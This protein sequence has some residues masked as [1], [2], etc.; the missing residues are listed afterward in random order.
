MIDART[1]VSAQLRCFV[2]VALP[3]Q[4]PFVA[5]LL[6]LLPLAIYVARFQRLRSHALVL[7]RSTSGSGNRSE[8]SPSRSVARR[9]TSPR[10]TRRCCCANREGVNLETRKPGRGSGTQEGTSVGIAFEGPNPEREMIL[11]FYFLDFWLP[12]S[13]LDASRMPRSMSL[14]RRRCEEISR[15][16]V[17]VPAA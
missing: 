5:R 2:Y 11:C 4:A 7:A 14:S 6:T 16:L 15:R 3:P 13:D 1:P 17:D 12:N 8:R 10:F 9:W